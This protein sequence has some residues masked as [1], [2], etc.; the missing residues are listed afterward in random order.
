MD[1]SN[2]LCCIYILICCL[3]ETKSIQRSIISK[4]GFS[5]N[6]SKIRLRRTSQ[7]SSFTDVQS[8]VVLCYDRKFIGAFTESWKN[9]THL[10]KTGEHFAGHLNAMELF[11]N[12]K[13]PSRP[14]L[15]CVSCISKLLLLDTEVRGNI[16]AQEQQKTP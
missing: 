9:C 7:I 16:M 13:N 4:E 10:A 14:L 1:L 15:Y 8:F 3:L 2:H 11:W 12:F 5:T 6:R